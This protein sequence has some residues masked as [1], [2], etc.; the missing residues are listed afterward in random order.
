MSLPCSTVPPTPLMERS[1][2]TVEQSAWESQEPARAST[3][4]AVANM[5][6]SERVRRHAK[7]SY[8]EVLNSSVPSFET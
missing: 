7:R 6:E 2:M 1:V 8:E 5:T 4:A 3:R